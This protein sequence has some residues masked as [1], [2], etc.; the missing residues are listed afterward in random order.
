MY[1][2]SMQ[3][4]VFLLVVFIIHYI[5]PQKVRYLWLF[6]ASCYF[7]MCWD[8]KYII[9]ILGVIITTFGGSLIIQKMRLFGRNKA[10]KVCLSAVIAVNFGLLFYFKYINFAI[11]NMNRLLRRMGSAGISTIETVLPV[12]ISFFVFQA[13]GYVADV[14]RGETDAERNFFRYALFVS[15]FPQ[16]VAGPIERS[17]NLLKQLA[18][19]AKLDGENIRAGLLYILFGVWQK[20]LLADNIAV[21][22]NK[23]YGDY[24]NYTGTQIFLATALFGIEIYCDFGGYTN[25]AI[26]SAKLFGI[27]LMQNFNA[28][29]LATSVTD[30]WRRWHI[31]LTSWFRDY[32]YIPLGGNRKGRTRKYKNTLIVFLISGLW[33]GAGWSYI[34]W[35]FF[36]GIY[37]VVENIFHKKKAADTMIEKWIKRIGTFL[38]VDITWF[39]FRAGSI[40]TAINMIMHA[41][42]RGHI[43]VRGMLIGKDMAL[44]GSSQTLL[45]IL[46]GIMILLVIGTIREKE[47]KG[48]VR[49]FFT[50]KEPVRWIIYFALIFMTIIYGAYGEGYGQTQF[51]Y[52]Q[53]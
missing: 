5:L 53:F 31:S 35:G 47:E 37:I 25:I 40:S 48:I 41:C 43:G 20:V 33:H 21:I 26:G 50:Q 52:F 7:Y 51:I 45:I 4:A 13:V 22:V 9:L 28:P 3:Y 49:L 1:F 19:P 8:A 14:Y 18:V 44:F 34:F 10:A 38:L 15:F 30:F 24:I 39:F 23:V 36:N 27:H 6:G 17:K 11:A 12:G 32:L 42:S 2:N 46:L 16:L 29:Y